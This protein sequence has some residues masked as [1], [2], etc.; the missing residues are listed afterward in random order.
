MGKE[1][2]G[3]AFP[4]WLH[5]SVLVAATLTGSVMLSDPTYPNPKH[6]SQQCI[7]PCCLHLYPL[8]WFMLNWLIQFS[9]NQ[10]KD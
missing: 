4:C 3:T 5:I 8:P 2:L 6:Q 7:T 1:L 10:G 9:I